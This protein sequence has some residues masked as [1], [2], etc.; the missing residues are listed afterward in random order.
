VVF[1]HGNG[2]LRGTHAAPLAAD[3]QPGWRK[4]STMRPGEPMTL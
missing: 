4:C 3:Y 1:D 2:D